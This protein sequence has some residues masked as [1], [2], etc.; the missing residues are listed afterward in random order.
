MPLCENINVDYNNI[1]ALIVV[2]TRELALQVKDEISDIGSL[3]LQIVVLIYLHII[4]QTH[5]LQYGKHYKN[6]SIF[7]LLHMLTQ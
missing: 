2:P 3:I 5:L 1:Q 7:L 6:E 4:Q